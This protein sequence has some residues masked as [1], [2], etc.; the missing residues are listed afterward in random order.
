M[1]VFVSVLMCVCVSGVL[2]AFPMHFDESSMFAGK[3]LEAKILKV[4][5]V[6]LYLTVDHI[7]TT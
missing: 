5:R 6:C 3:K 2:R 7:S 4:E 1:C